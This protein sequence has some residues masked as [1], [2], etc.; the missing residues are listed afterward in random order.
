MPLFEVAMIKVPTPNEVKGGATEELVM[1]PT[2]VIAANAQTA[3]LIVGR[4]AD[5]KDMSD[6]DLGRIQTLIR[7]FAN[8][9]TG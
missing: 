2:A 4:K 9:A 5:L 6:K 1:A 7:P 8:G 3:A